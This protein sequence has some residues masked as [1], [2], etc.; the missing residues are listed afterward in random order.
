[1]RFKVRGFYGN[2]SNIWRK[3]IL[4]KICKKSKVLENHK[5][6]PDLSGLPRLSPSK[7]SKSFNRK[8][9]DST[10]G[11]VPNT[12]PKP[13]V[14]TK[15]Q[16]K[17]TQV[18]SPSRRLPRPGGCRRG[19]AP[20]AAVLG[21]TGSASEAAS[22]GLSSTTTARRGPWS[23]RA[24]AGAPSCRLRPSPA[25]GRRS[26]SDRWMTSSTRGRDEQLSTTT[27]GCCWCCAEGCGRARLLRR[28]TLPWPA[29]TGSCPRRL[30]RGKN[31]ARKKEYIQRY[32][33]SP[34]TSIVFAIH[35]VL[36]VLV[37]TALITI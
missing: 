25:R 17:P 14:R 37:H 4:Q 33:Q 24:G 6:A 18:I 3:K 1:M 31:S 16:V 32:E 30:S 11:V 28:G 29:A 9:A 36:S 2:C 22:A 26:S 13:M 10:S 20:V 19:R 23:T 7:N 15:A 34:R 27:S 5:S 8:L 12:Y 21:W 35:T